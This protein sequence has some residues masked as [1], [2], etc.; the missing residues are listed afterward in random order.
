MFGYLKKFSGKHIAIDSRPMIVDGGLPEFV[1]NFQG[2][3]EFTGEDIDPQAPQSYGEPYDT[4]IFFDSD[5]AHDK[6]TRRS[7][8][9][10]LVFVGRTPITWISRRHVA[11][12]SSTYEAEFMA[13]RTA[14]EEAKSL[15]CQNAK[16]SRSSKRYKQNNGILYY[17][18]FSFFL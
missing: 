9:G 12:A 4:S 16:I 11:I 15:R 5:H 8:S 13:M 1:A 2:D 10:I 6:K 18:S 3:Y 17:L 14:V 7:I